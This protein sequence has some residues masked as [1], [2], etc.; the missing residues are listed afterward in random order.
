MNLLKKENYGD[1]LHKITETLI[2]TYKLIVIMA[3]MVIGFMASQ[4]Y[5]KYM[6]GISDKAVSKSHPKETV[7]VAINDLHELMIVD[8][9]TGTYDIYPDSV[10]FKIFDIVAVTHYQ[11]KTGGSK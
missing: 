2:K 3:A 1:L 5:N 11:Q 8:R 9:K 6:N 7:T 10:A 4:L